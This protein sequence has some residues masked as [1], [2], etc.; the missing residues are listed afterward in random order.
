VSTDRRELIATL[1]R[2]MRE[3][4]AQGVLFSHA[5][6]AQARI[7]STDLEC[8]DII[9]LSGRA[10]AGDLAKA[11][12]LTTGAM[13]GVLDRLESAG[14]VQRQRDPTDRRKVWITVLPAVESQIAPRFHA[15]AAA[16]D[17]VLT[18]YD[19]ATLATMLEFHRRARQV[20][21]R[22][23]ENLQA[24]APAKRERPR[25]ATG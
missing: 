8:L 16:I 23:T 20:L 11:T 22:E 12:G 1:M 14:F 6:A 10:T 19:T 15:L 2:A 17:A 25:R 4:S 18:D 3:S 7:A 24:T 21:V 13:T 9:L 5:V